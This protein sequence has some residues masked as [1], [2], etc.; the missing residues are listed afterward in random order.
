MHIKLNS[1]CTLKR[2]T[3]TGSITTAKKAENTKYMSF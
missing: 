3:V 2:F 1:R